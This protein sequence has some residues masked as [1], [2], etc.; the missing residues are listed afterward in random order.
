MLDTKLILRKEGQEKEYTDYVDVKDFG[1]TFELG[2]AKLTGDPNEW[3]AYLK[4]NNLRA[5]VDLQFGDLKVA[6]ANNGGFDVDPIF[7]IKEFI[8]ANQKTSK[9]GSKSLYRGDFS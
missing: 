1:F 4:L 7:S 5:K 2:A 8:E 9:K 3:Q 6:V